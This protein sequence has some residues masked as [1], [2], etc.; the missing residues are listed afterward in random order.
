MI[1]STLEELP[2]QA[3]GQSL[4]VVRGS[5]VRAR[6]FLLDIVASFRGLIGGEIVEYSKLQGQ[7]REQALQRLV[8]HAQFLGADAVLGIRMT[9]SMITQGASEILVYGTAV[10]LI[11]SP[12][13]QTQKG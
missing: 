13:R 12:G 11:P 3:I 2:N 6:N 9:T 7:S 5:T 1:L 10:K 4:G 8:D